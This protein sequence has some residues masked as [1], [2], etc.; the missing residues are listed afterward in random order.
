MKNTITKTIGMMLAILMLTVFTQI[1]ATAQEDIVNEEKSVE[2]TQEEEDLSLQRRNARA[3]E[4]VWNHTNTR[5][6]CATGEAIQTFAVMHTYMRGGTMSDWGAGSPPSLRSKGQ[7]IWN[8]QSR[9]N[10]ITA[11]QFFRFN[12]DG[13]YAGKQVVREQIQ[14]SSSG[15][16]YNATATAQV[17]DAGGNVIANNCSTGTA[18]RFE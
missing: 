7:G 4:G 12:A 10:Y 15:N 5:R 14:L 13:T 9:R 3:L 17:F 1:S 8:Y 18:T 2:Q 16:S 6:N 11:F